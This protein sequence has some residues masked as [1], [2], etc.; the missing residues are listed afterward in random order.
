VLETRGRDHAQ[1]VLEA[2]TRAGFDVRV[3]R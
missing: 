1:R 3:V 2:L